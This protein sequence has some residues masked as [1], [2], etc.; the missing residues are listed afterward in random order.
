MP[1]VSGGPQGGLVGLFNNPT[2][3]TTFSALRPFARVQSG[4]QQHHRSVGQ[5]DFN[6]IAVFTSEPAMESTDDEDSRCIRNY[7]R[8]SCGVLFKAVRVGFNTSAQ[9]RVITARRC[10]KTIECWR[11]TLLLCYSI[12]R[13]GAEACL[14]IL[15]DFSRRLRQ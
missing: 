5:S 4:K 2:Y 10:Q 3:E 1:P 9:L 13:G 12:R 8:G 7:R 6:G 11:A 15:D 14:S